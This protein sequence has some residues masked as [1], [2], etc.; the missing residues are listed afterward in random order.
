[1]PHFVI[2]TG[3][4]RGHLKNRY[5]NKE[6][7]I[8]KMKLFMGG[9]VPDFHLFKTHAKDKNTDHVSNCLTLRIKRRQSGLFV[10]CGD[11]TWWCTRL[12]AKSWKGIPIWQNNIQFKEIWQS[13]QFKDEIIYCCMDFSVVCSIHLFDCYLILIMPQPYIPPNS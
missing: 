11:S 3:G 7:W 8:T 13:V 6:A 2:R 10:N 4:G 5:I 1:M 9:I 12:Y